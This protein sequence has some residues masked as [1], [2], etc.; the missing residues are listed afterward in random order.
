M[1]C[2]RAD[3]QALLL[4]YM[5]QAGVELTDHTCQ[6]LDQLIDHIIDAAVEKVFE[7]QAIRQLLEA[8]P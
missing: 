4:H 6:E 7:S 5:E 8:H 3:A 1:E 2:P